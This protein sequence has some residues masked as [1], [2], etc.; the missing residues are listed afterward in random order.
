MYSYLP[1]DYDIRL[2]N[3][4]DDQR[5]NIIEKKCNY[6]GVVYVVTDNKSARRATNHSNVLY[7]Y[8]LL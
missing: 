8:L 4:W 5:Y 7:E 2:A 1:V 3:E 6:I